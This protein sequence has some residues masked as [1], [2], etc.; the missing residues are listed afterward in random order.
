MTFLA[1]VIILCLFAAINLYAAQRLY[2][3]LKLILPRIKAAVFVP[4]YIIFAA[5]MMLC[6]MRSS[7]PFSVA[8][9]RALNAFGAYCMGIFIY[10]FLFFII[11]DIIFLLGRAF[12]LISDSSRKRY[13][14]FSGAVVLIL[15]AITV[16][17]GA[18]HAAQI[19]LVSYDAEIS[20]EM[21]A[22]LISDLHLGAAGSE[23]RFEKT[24][25]AVNSLEPDIVFI[26]G[27]IFDNDFDIISDTKQMSELFKSIDT[28]YGVYA[29]LGNH[30]AGSTIGE[31]ISFLKD[32]D[33]T[34][35][36][37]EATV[38]DNRLVLIGR[39]DSSPIGGAGYGVRCDISELM[40]GVD[41]SMP[42]VVMDH[43]PTNID[44]YPDS[45]DL[46]LCGHTHKGQ[47]FPGELFTNA[48]FDVDYGYYRKDD[49]SP[50]VIVTSGA[51]AW[52]MPM[53]VGTDCEVVSIKLH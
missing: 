14:L 39:R 7:L 38:I 46:I 24:V 22:V 33:V 42:I 31:M 19:K 10:M 26:S 53:R 23:R 49:N 32:S 5:S 48:M 13:R 34:L 16:F 4:L 50:Q 37:D 11:S 18:V 30:D 45:V 6:F 43:N 44:E 9:K 41:T 12:R 20:A 25:A 8:V 17:Y 51:G 3:W 52:G 15:T 1:P 40:D 29:C 35:L 21:N 36:S 28:K 27:D 2:K 47:M